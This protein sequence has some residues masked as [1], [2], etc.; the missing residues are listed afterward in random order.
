MSEGLTLVLAGLAGGL[1]GAIFFGGLW[2]TVRKGVASPRAALWFLLSAVLRMALVVT[3]FY[4]VGGGQGRRL[5][6][7][8]VGFTLARLVAT[9]WRRAPASIAQPSP[10]GASHAP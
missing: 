6:A 4:L 10:G 2:W 3:G 5:V 8:L 9:R 1:L 7:A